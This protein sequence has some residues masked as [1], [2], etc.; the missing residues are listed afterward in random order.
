M[1][2]ENVNKYLDKPIA[3][4]SFRGADDI[5]KC[6]SWCLDTA[7]WRLQ[8]CPS[9]RRSDLRS[10]TAA[11]DILRFSAQWLQNP[12]TSCSRR[13]RQS[14]K[15]GQGVDAISRSVA[16]MIGRSGSGCTIPC[17]GLVRHSRAGRTA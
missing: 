2:K 8:A 1:G 15:S 6:P 5:V 16:V 14:E 10:S 11:K 17:T 12:R 7:W 13:R 4:V 9:T 3:S